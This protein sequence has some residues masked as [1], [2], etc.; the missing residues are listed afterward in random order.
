MLAI[1][2]ALLVAAPDVRAQT[3]YVSNSEASSVS[4][5]DTA[6]NAVVG[7]PITVGEG[8]RGIAIAPNGS[9]AYVANTGPNGV[10]VVS[11]DFLSTPDGGISTQATRRVKLLLGTARRHGGTAGAGRR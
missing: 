9:K 7:S 1:G 8:P 2:L 11:P 3:L 10:S 5:I 6:T 4:V